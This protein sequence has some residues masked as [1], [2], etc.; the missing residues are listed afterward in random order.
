MERLA[1]V[2]ASEIRRLDQAATRDYGIPALLLMENAGRAVSDVISREYKPC[3]VL[4]FVGKGNNGGD[5][6]VVARH[7]ANR[8]FHVRVV[9]LEDPAKLKADPLL[10]FTIVKKM[11]IPL[12]L[13]TE[14]STDEELSAHC[15][16]ADLVIDAIFGVG[17]HS[18]LSGIFEKAVRAINRNGKFVIS[19]DIPSGLD[20][21]T[22][23]VHG[24]VVKATRTV[25]LALP[26]LGLFAGEGPKCAGKVE[27]VDIGIP[28]E[29]LLPFFRQG[30]C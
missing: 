24:V 28:R 23:Q 6:L 19:I 11:K 8:G 20:A 18:P 26:K 7:L 30:A 2:S 15:S 13:M 10:N 17:I 3:K 29:L 22:G 5:G 25:T 16:E 12:V 21:D 4:I 1:P 9:L 27:C 14:N